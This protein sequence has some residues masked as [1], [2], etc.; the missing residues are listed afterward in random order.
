MKTILRNVRRWIFG[1]TAA[2]HFKERMEW[3]ARW[4]RACAKCWHILKGPPS[5]ERFQRW[6]RNH[7]RL[8]R[9]AEMK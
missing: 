5:V 9:L 6:E 8:C 3:L 7:K 4:D 1:P 2:E